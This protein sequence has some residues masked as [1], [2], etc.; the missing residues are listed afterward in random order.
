MCARNVEKKKKPEHKCFKNYEGSSSSMEQ[1]IIT[2]GFNQSISQHGLKYKKFIA[3]GDSSVYA[4]IKS[5]VNYGNEVEKIECTN[6]AIKNFV[7]TLYKIKSDKNIS[8][9][10]RRLLT[11]K[12][13]CDFKK[14][15]LAVIKFASFE[16]NVKHLRCDINNSIAHIFGKHDLCRRSICSEKN[17]VNFEC[18]E[19]T[20]ETGIYYHLT[21]KIYYKHKK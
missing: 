5:R 17:I 13:I 9:A 11:I 7:K 20:K 10:G 2:E 16:K 14:H 4:N 12:K 3:D 1:D 15:L 19:K 21:G 6:H 18:F 8:I